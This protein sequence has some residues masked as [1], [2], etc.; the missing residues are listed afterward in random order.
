[1][2]ETVYLTYSLH[3]IRFLTMKRK[4]F[5]IGYYSLP[6]IIP[7]RSVPLAGRNKMDYTIDVLADIFERIEII[8]PARCKNEGEKASSIYVKIR[9]H[10]YLTLFNS[11]G[12]LPKLLDNLFLA[13]QLLFY[14]FSHIRHGD[15]VLVYH[16]LAYRKSLLLA[17]R[18]IRFKLV[19]E[20]NEVFADVDSRFEKYRNYEEEIIK[21]ADAFLFP[22]DLMNFMFNKQNKPYAVEYGI[23]KVEKRQSNHFDDGLIHVVYAG[24]FDPSKG[25]NIVV[26][27]AQYLPEKYHI[28]ILGFGNA[29]LVSSIENIINEVQRET[30][31]TIT[32]DGTLDGMSFS[33]FLQKCHI[34]LS[35][36]NP[37]ASFNQTSFPSKI[38]TYL[39]NGLQVVSIDIPAIS[40]S[41][42]KDSIVFYQKQTPQE[43]A[44]SI[45]TIKDFT[46]Q[47]H[48]LEDLDKQLR[49]QLKDL[50]MK[51]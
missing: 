35:P 16:S 34:G 1:M 42:L 49:I 2:K 7:E 3:L 26:S 23:Y 44:H 41:K 31:C 29:E 5:Y 36:Q 45:L 39:A 21:S 50:F 47:Y 15:I 20:L 48:I 27:T 24:T 51:V 40:Q 30:K 11:L 32:Y 38:L 25:V 10:V 28:H 6:S 19:L 12:T 4:L 17:K 22:N 13:L 33:L 46:P 9:E 14:I 43:I 37:L 18:I 8:S